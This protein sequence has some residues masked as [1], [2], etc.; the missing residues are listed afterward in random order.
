MWVGTHDDVLAQVMDGRA[1]AGAIKDTRL[2]LLLRNNPAW[3]V[4]RLATSEAVPSNGLLLHPR[5]RELVPALTE[6]LLAMDKEP[7]GRAVLEAMG[8]TA[9]VPCRPEE[10]GPIFD[11]VDALGEGCA[12]RGGGRPAA[13]PAE[14]AGRPRSGTELTMLRRKLILTFGSLIAL[15]AVMSI[16]AI[17]LLQGLLRELDHVNGHG[18][19]AAEHASSMSATMT[20]IQME[21]YSL[22][23]DRTRHLDGLIAGVTRLRQ[24]AET[25]SATFAS[26][27]TYARP[28]CQA[29]LDRLPAF[30]QHVSSLAT[31]QDAEL[32][33]QYNVTALGDAVGLLTHIRRLEAQVHGHLQQE[34]QAVAARFRWLVLG[35]AVGFLLVINVSIVVLLRAAGMVLG[36]STSWWRPAASWPRS[37]STTAWSWTSRT[38]STSWPAA[39]TPWPSSS[40]A[41]S[42]GS[43]RRSGRWRWR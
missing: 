4:R 35:L 38:S 6:L 30:E 40:R 41:T 7:Q 43:W 24:L 31:A 11:M 33:R 28:D 25:M 22:Q 42:G 13:Q 23:L 10:Y 9:F 12:R 39:T 1:D 17:L 32:T 20:G 5:H 27:E 16:A 8:A 21:L 36:R 14:P 18:M 29:I 37:A 26:Q 2:E 3:R 15:L 19:A 34:Q